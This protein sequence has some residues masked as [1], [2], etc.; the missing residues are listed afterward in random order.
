M[1]DIDTL[2]S[3]GLG[4]TGPISGRLTT[5]ANRIGVSSGDRTVL[6][7]AITKAL[8]AYVKSISGA[9]VAVAEYD[10]LINAL[11]NINQN[12]AAFKEALGKYRMAIKRDWDAE[13][14]FAK[15]QHRDTDYLEAIAP[16]GGYSESLGI[17]NR[18]GSPANSAVTSLSNGTKTLDIPSDNIEAIEEAKRQGYK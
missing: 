15:G 10:R 13:V 18:T 17:D 4:D 6:I 2:L 11:P 3:K 9:Q 14:A 8:A 16:K 5:I 1:G 12:P 7:S